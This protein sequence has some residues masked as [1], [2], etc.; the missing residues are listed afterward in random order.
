MTHPIIHPEDWLILPEEKRLLKNRTPHGKFGFAVLLK[1]FQAKGRFPDYQAEVNQEILAT[2]AEQVGI[3]IKTWYDLDWEGRTIKRIRA[4]IREWSGFREV[5]LSDLDIFKRWL[6]DEVIFREHRVDRLRELLLQRC[7]EMRVEPPAS[8]HGRRLIQSA[9]Q[10]HEVRFCA[11]IFQCMDSP[12]FRRLDSFL[13]S[14]SCDE[15]GVE[16]TLWQA[17]K[18]EPGKAGLNSV[19]EAVSRLKLVRNVELPA[20]LFKGVPPKLIERYAKRAA[21]EE[22]FELRRHDDLLRFTLLAVFLHRRSE[23]LTDHMVDLLVETVHKMGKKAERRIDDSLGE[24]LQKAPSKMIKLY[25]IAKASVDSPK[26]VV[27][28]VIFSAPPLPM[29]SG[30]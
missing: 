6:V 27:E 18:G 20:G 26:G 23:E 16:W 19:K 15:D 14:Q 21:V 13:K 11:G 7:R 28:D 4:E 8:E 3:P 10:E 5:T 17:I 1:F 2:I 12:I 29:D 25:R 30:S 9:L 22:P 24:E